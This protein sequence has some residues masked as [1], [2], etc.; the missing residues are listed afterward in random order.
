MILVPC[1]VKGSTI[2]KLN[3]LRKHN[4]N[5]KTLVAIGGLNEGLIK[6]STV[7]NSATLRTKFVTNLL[8]FVKE[9]R[10]NGLD[11]DWEYLTESKGSTADWVN[12][13][14]HICDI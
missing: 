9:Y 11:I 14:H 1:F 6:F 4:S 3:H 5:L 13:A 8:N 10:V 2:Y 7:C 12:I